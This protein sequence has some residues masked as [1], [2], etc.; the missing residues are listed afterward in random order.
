MLNKQLNLIIHKKQTGIF[1]IFTTSYINAIQ[2][3]TM[4]WVYK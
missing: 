4:Q 1:Q 2:D 3:R